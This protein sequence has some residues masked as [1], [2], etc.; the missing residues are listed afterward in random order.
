MRRQP[1]DPEPTPPRGAT[2]VNTRTTYTM[3]DG[4]LAVLVPADAIAITVAH[5]GRAKT[6]WIGL[7]MIDDTPA[8]ETH[9]PAEV[10]RMWAELQSAA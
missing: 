3:D 4:T 6:V 8:L 9:L 1:P 10:R 5:A 7:E 2:K